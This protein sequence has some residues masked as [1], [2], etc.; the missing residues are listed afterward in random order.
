MVPDRVRERRS[1]LIDKLPSPV[2]KRV[3]RLG[4]SLVPILQCALAAGTAW[5]IANDLLGHPHPFFAP[6]SSVLS[7]GL[8]LVRRWRRSLELM[9]GVLIGILVGD[10]IIAKVGSGPWQIMIVVAAAMVVAVVLDGAPMVTNQAAS[11]A[12][13]VATLLP[14]GGGAGWERGIDA[15]VGGGVGLLIG[16]LIPVNPAH[17]GRRDA[18]ALLAT[19]RDLTADLAKALAHDDEDGV[20]VVLTKARGTQAAVDAMHSDMLAGRELSRMSPLYWT[21]RPRLESIAQRASPIDNSIRNL[22]IIARRAVG[23]TRRGVR[24]DPVVVDVL[25]DMS[26]AFEVLRAMML[27]PPKGRPDPA[28]AARQVRSIVRVLNSAIGDEREHLAEG[29]GDLSAAALLVEMRSLLVDMLMI[30]GLK[31]ESALA[32][33]HLNR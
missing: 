23:L 15:L 32:Q 31:R 7:M 12:V 1:Q 25:G 27:A 11:S 26:S 4:L 6:I 19:L 3:R 22:R 30:A 28:D 33:L 20:N 2:Q 17:R 16:A 5:W 29:G 10:L 13:L 14:P 9:G 18:A 8:I 21:E 24:L